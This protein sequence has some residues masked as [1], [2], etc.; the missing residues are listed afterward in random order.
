MRRLPRRIPGRHGE[1]HPPGLLL[2][3]TGGFH[4]PMLRARRS[5]ER[6]RSPGEQ[7]SLLLKKV[8]YGTPGRSGADVSNKCYRD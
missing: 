3:I 4:F 6:C 1:Q 5:R 8:I 2:G 7:R